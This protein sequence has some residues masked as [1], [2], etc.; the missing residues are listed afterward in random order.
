M[1]VKIQTHTEIKKLYCSKTKAEEIRENIMKREERK[2]EEVISRIEAEFPESTE[3]VLS[4]LA[5][6]RR[7]RI[8]TDKHS[9]FLEAK[10]K[11]IMGR[12][13]SIMW[14]YRETQ[15]G[16]GDDFWAVIPSFTPSKLRRTKKL[17]KTYQ[18]YLIIPEKFENMIAKRFL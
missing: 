6:C 2:A 1:S 17:S 11:C 10:D 13:H 8:A 4:A 16:L 18:I 7:K 15:E 3:E 5:S 9:A 12:P 14:E